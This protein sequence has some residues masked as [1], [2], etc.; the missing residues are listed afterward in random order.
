MPTRLC[1]SSGCPEPVV[2]RGRCRLHARANNRATH[3]N[4][5][6]RRVYNSKRWQLLRK[7]VLFEQP[8]CAGCDDALAVDVDH[9]TS[10]DHGGAPYDRANVQGL[11]PT[12]HGRKTRQEQAT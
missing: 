3:S 12:C 7:R 9:I 6:N 11:C 8:I 10:L 2:T 1:S 4:T 5:T